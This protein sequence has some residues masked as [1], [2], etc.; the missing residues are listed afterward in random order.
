MQRPLRGVEGHAGGARGTDQEALVG[1][2]ELCPEEGEGPTQRLA[3]PSCTRP[4]PVPSRGLQRD[5]NSGGG[6][7][8][9]AA[10]SLREGEGRQAGQRQ[11]R[12]GPGMN[13]RFEQLEEEPS[14]L[15]GVLPPFP[16]LQRQSFSGSSRRGAAETN[17]ISIHEDVGSILGLAQWVKDL[18]LP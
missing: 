7:D 4:P 16:Q 2:P 18:A 11:G 12:S 10:A 14:R 9:R 8:A 3:L 5:P 6:G 15:E 13:P 17:P 1:L